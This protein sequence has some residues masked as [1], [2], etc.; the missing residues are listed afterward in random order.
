MLTNGRNGRTQPRI[1]NGR[2]IPPANYVEA[3]ER[4][5]RLGAEIQ[6]V[7]AQLSD[8]T[9]ALNRDPAE[10]AEWRRRANNILCSFRLEERL[11]GEWIDARI[12]QL[13]SLENA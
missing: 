2:L 6:R 9:R 5:R 1:K 7:Q 3:V 10:H 12:E 13:V 4:H 8:P 11:L